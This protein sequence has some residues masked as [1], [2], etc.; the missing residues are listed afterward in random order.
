MCIYITI[1]VINHGFHVLLHNSGWVTIIHQP[2][3]CGQGSCGLWGFLKSNSHHCDR[4]TW[5]RYNHWLTPKFWRLTTLLMTV[6]SAFLMID[7]V[8]IYIYMYVRVCMY[9]WMDGWIDGWMDVWMD[10]SMDG[11]MDGCMHAC[12]HVCMHVNV[13]N[14]IVF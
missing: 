9:G 7:N 8:C 2:E 1:W 12:M 6:N 4:S 3:N 5:G 14:F 11:C 13:S 10:G